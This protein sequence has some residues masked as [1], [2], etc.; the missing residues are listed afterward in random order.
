MPP[1]S[2]DVRG[3]FSPLEK[4]CCTFDFEVDTTHTYS[5]SLTPWFSVSSFVLGLIMDQDFNET[6]E[7]R[8]M[9]HRESA[10]DLVT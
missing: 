6:V 8:W 5:C 2:P 10:A 4:I 7:N 3:A 9:N 1:H